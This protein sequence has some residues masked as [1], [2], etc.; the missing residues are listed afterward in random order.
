MGAIK[1][2]QGLWGGGQIRGKEM[3][4]MKAGVDGKM[5]GEG[6]R[7]GRGMGKIKEGNK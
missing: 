1:K 3:G 6:W 7:Q 2:K 4:W 5:L